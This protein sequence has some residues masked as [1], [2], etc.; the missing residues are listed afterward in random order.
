MECKK[1][2]ELVKKEYDYI[3]ENGALSERQERILWL[4]IKDYSIVQIANDEHVNLSTA[5]V[6][7]EIENIR[8]KMT[9]I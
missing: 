6:S 2:K 3:C 4:R 8:K 9:K 1:F 7:R 5:Q